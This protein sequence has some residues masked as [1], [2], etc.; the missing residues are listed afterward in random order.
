MF[1]ISWF[2]NTNK[3]K[4]SYYYNNNIESK[5]R[6]IEPIIK[7]VKVDKTQI[8]IIT[9]TWFPIQFTPLRP[10]IILKDYC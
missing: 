3:K 5:W 2:C 8:F 7:Y 9:S 1:Q 4:N 6:P 10:S